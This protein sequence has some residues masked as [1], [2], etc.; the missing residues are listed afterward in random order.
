[1]T[2]GETCLDFAGRHAPRALSH[3]VW[4]KEKHPYFCDR[5]APVDLD[6]EDKEGL[7]DYRDSVKRRLSDMRSD[8]EALTKKS[9]LDWSDIVLCELFKVDEAIADGDAAR[10][11][12]GLYACAAVCLRVVDVLEGRQ[13][14]GKPEAKGDA[15]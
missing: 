14:L 10:A 7:A 15:E 1:M 11:V 4:A 5:I 6:K 9:E 3:Y 13:K 8:I 2:D 12:E